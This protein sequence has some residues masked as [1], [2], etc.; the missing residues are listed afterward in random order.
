MKNEEHSIERYREDRRN[1][2]K[3]PRCALFVLATAAGIILLALSLGTAFAQRTDAPGSPTSATQIL[4]L[5]TSG[6]PPLHK[7]RSEP[8]TMLSV[9]GRSY[10]IDCGIGTMRRMLEAG[11]HSEQI[12]TIF[13]THLHSDHDLGLADVMANDFFLLGSARY[14]KSI[15]IYGPAQTKELV[16]AAVRYISISV[17]PF[18]AENP[19][20]Y[21]AV[22][23]EF[24]NP[25]VAHEIEQEGVIFQDDK[26]RVIAAENTHYALM[27]AKDRVQLKSYS[28]RFETPQGVVVFTGDTGPNSEAVIRLSKD[29]DVL[30]AEASSRDPKD[31]D[32]F[33]NLRATRDHWPPDQLKEFR[34]HFQF[35]HLD[36]HSVGELATQAQVKSVLLYHYN[37]L[38]KAD[39]AAFVSGVKGYFSGPVFA[40]A[41]LDRYCLGQSASATSA[42]SSVLKPCPEQPRTR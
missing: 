5:G 23:K 6:G 27:P 30:V 26:I 37:P 29:A 12:K 21:R 36:S 25:F 18:A 10:L 14:A 31:L 28:Y 8:S 33:V 4:V 7:D 16:D 19:S 22:G 15:N 3:L 24:A 2:S 34:A 11:I 17:R 40:S 39:E 42:T 38:N 41:D 1:S 13:I 32:R 35:E 9:D 20:S